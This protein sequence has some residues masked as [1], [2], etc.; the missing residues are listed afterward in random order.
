MS[1]KRIPQFAKSIDYQH[2]PL[3][4][5]LSAGIRQLELD[6]YGDS[7][8]GL[9]ANP[10]GPHHAANYGLPPDSSFD[11]EDI[12]KK[13]GFKVFHIQDIDYRSSCEPFIAC[14]FSIHKWSLAHP[15]H[16]PIFILIENKDG[17]GSDF[18]AKP[19]PVTR[20]TFDELDAVIRSVFA[21]SE[22]VTPDDVR[23]N[24]NTLEEAILTS[25]WP[26]L[27]K[28]LG[29]V[30]FL[31]DQRR[32]GAMYALDHPSLEGRV[33]FTNSEPGEPDAAFVEV[34]D[35]LND[36]RVIQ[37]LVRRGYLVRTMTDPGPDGVRA[38]DTK[39][40]DAALASGAQILSTDY[41]FD[42]RAPSGY[43]V[44]FTKGTVRCD[45]IVNT[46]A[47]KSSALTNVQ[48]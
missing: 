18:M 22:I 2:P 39:R 43:S 37:S 27:D 4:V 28:T 32:F 45:P 40:C 46:G 30:I 47:C 9:F 31:L 3:T 41:P 14:L 25:G 15:Q 1:E 8:G 13:P 7:K 29:K 5:Q 42:E 12:M 6:V 35:P 33:M 19:E 16:L 17:T 11:P 36:L 23:G 48:P 26:T 20:K 44:Y 38:N 21:L 10:A 34:N 24:Q